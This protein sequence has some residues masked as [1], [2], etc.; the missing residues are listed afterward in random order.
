MPPLHVVIGGLGNLGRHFQR[1]LLEHGQSVRVI[2]AITDSARVA[3]R[4]AHRDVKYFPCRLGSAAG[5]QETLQTAL[6]GADTVYTMVTANVH[7]GTVREMHETNQVG[8]QQVLEA[9]QQVGVPKLVHVSSFA[10]ANHFVHYHQANEETPLPPLETY[11]SAYDSTKRLGE[12]LV[13][14]ANSRNFKTTSLRSGGIL[15]GIDDYNFG[16]GGIIPQ[17]S[18]ILKWRGA[19]KDY[20][21]AKDLSRALWQASSK[22]GTDKKLAGRAIYVSNCKTNQGVQSDFVTSRFAEM[23]GFGTLELSWGFIDR[24]MIPSMRLGE[25]LDALLKQKSHQ[26]LAAFPASLLVE[27]TRYESTF[28]NS[29]G[30]KLLDYEPEETWTDAVDWIAQEFRERHPELIPKNATKIY[31]S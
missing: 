7:S 28:D 30:R 4:L 12:E 21:S 22:L 17:L 9:C 25:Q 8:I 23:I 19:P 31:Q 1:T 5:V 16:S 29:L 24:V 6:Q 27:C 3:S 10:V 14:Q 20:T 26:D 13:L 2:D 15:A 18:R 11:M